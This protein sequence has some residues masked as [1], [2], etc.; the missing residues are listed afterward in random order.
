MQKFRRIAA[1]IGVILLVGMYVITLILA[2]SSSPN[3]QNMLMA[4]IACTVIIPVFI[5]AMI[6]VARVVGGRGVDEDGDKKADRKED[7]KKK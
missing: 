1:M 6:L 7:N 5:Y 3:A 4:S 2:L